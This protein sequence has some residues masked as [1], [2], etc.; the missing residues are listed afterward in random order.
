MKIA[1][2]DLYLTDAQWAILEPMLPPAKRR[3]RPRTCLRR[4]IDAIFYLA[5][6]GGAWRLLPSDFPAWKTVYH[7]F[8]RWSLDG[9]W[10][11]IN[12]ILRS[13]VRAQEGRRSRPTAGI[14]DS[15]TVRSDAHGGT[16]GYDG[17]KKVKGR[18]RFVCGD[19]LGLIL[20]VAVL[21][22]DCPER[23]GAKVLLDPVLRRHAWLRKI[24]ADGGFSGPDLDGW[25]RERRP[26]GDVEVVCR[27]P[28]APGFRVL[29]RR[30]V[31]ERTFAW[32]SQH[33]RLA[34]DYEKTT[35]SAAA[36]VLAAM[37]RLMIRR[38]P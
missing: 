11:L 20:G 35:H 17:G 9:T 16:V 14:I 21:P 3:G 33:R 12:D 24:W 28:G 18:K 23:Q 37:S 32:L 29:P 15:Q 25:V 19:V 34:R 22:G 13:L 38:L 6:S 4:V 2:S 30:W 31:V 27:T 36:W 5:K 10:Q 8:R 7:H 26:K 1:Y